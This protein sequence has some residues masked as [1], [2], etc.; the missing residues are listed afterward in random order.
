MDRGAVRRERKRKARE[1]RL[2]QEKH[3]RRFGGRGLAGFLG[4]GGPPPGVKLAITVADHLRIPTERMFFQMQTRCSLESGGFCDSADREDAQHIAYDALEA[5]SPSEAVRLAKTALDIDPEC[6]D[7]YLVLAE[8][9]PYTAERL[10]L[11]RMAVD[12]ARKALGEMFEEERGRFWRVNGT[13][14]Y[15]RARARLAREL[16]DRGDR[17]EAIS[18]LEA[19]LE[20]NPEDN[21]GLRDPLLGQYL[22]AGRLKEAR[23]LLGR[24]RGDASAVF[25]WG[26]A[27]TLLL[28][29]RDQDA[30]RAADRARRRAPLAEPYF[31]GVEPLPA[32]SPDMY[33]VGETSEAAHAAFMIGPAWALHP[34]ASS[35]L[36]DLPWT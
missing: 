36:R 24:Y 22:S 4:G 6:S 35:W 7:A 27:L 20:L 15:M 3:E 34:E 28:E 13:R 30:R 9:E 29:G 25:L 2:R 33:F 8:A 26:E 17:E 23:K 19:L 32:Q 10:P 1:E 16:I 5:K 11:L 31:Q 14:P 18:H 21:Q 12:F